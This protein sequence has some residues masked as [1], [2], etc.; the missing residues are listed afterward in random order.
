MY[1]YGEIFI[2][3]HYERQ[4]SCGF[5]KCSQ[6]FATDHNDYNITHKNNSKINKSHCG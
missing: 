6:T 2:S 1:R 4:V 5:L 3:P